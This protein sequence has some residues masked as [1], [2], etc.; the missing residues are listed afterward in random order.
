[1]LRQTPQR[2]HSEVPRRIQNS[3]RQFRGHNNSGD[4]ILISRSPTLTPPPPPPPRH[5]GRFKPIWSELILSFD[6]GATATLGR[7]AECPVGLRLMIQKKKSWER[8]AVHRLEL[9]DRIADALVECALKQRVRV[10]EILSRR[11]QSEPHYEKRQAG[12]W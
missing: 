10:P 5:S 7:M 12:K 9:T 11:F 1:M 6:K 3:D 4:T 2:E 8:P